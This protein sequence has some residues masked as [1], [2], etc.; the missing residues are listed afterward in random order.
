[1]AS[2]QAEEPGQAV[3]EWSGLM[4]KFPEHPLAASAQ[5][6]IGEAYYRQ[7]DF[8]QAIVE[9]RK[10]IDGYANSPQVPEALL[11]I[12]LC[13][14]ALNDSARARETWEQL[15]KEFPASNAASQAHALLG[16]APPSAQPAR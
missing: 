10:V 5:Y 16:G 12:G 3:L 8:H 13:Y 11:K 4:Q 15:S 2:F 1:M 9:F 6:W 7:R 14:R